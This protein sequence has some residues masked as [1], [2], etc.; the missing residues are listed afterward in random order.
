MESSWSTTRT[1]FLIRGDGISST[2]SRAQ[3]GMGGRSHRHPAFRRRDLER[4]SRGSMRLTS[5]KP[6]PYNRSVCPSTFGVNF[7]VR[8][9][10]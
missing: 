5:M 9:L 1:I 4:V 10:T 3:E 7:T 6:G 8:L 2:H